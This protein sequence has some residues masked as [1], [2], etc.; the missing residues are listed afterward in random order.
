MYL[1]TAYLDDKS[2]KELQSIIDEIATAAGNDFMTAN[3][4]MPHLTVSAFDE[5][6]E[7]ATIA[8]FEKMEERLYSD[9]IIIPS[10]GVFLPY[11]IYAEAVKNEYLLNLS[12]DIFNILDS[13]EDTRI[14]KYYKP[15]NWIPHITLG[16]KLEK[17]ELHVAFNIVQDRFCPITARI[18]SFG[19]S[20]PNPLR[21][22]RS[23]SFDGKCH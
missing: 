15:Y 9:E 14:N 12:K 8:L 6:S 16:K 18:T 10:V 23:A 19:L 20:K 13:N 21:N 1:I 3:N 4:V 22:L 17:E 5:R 2:T 11:V 7:D